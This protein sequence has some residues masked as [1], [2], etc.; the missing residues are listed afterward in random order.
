LTKIFCEVSDCQYNT[1][2]LCRRRVIKLKLLSE[3][4]LGEPL[5]FL[6]CQTFK[7]RREEE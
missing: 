5:E 7:S 3:E 4:Q 6:D 2:G 1:G